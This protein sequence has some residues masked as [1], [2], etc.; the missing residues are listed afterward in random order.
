MNG[1]RAKRL[2]RE[3]E[4]LTA[5]R[6]DVQYRERTMK[7]VSVPIPGRTDGHMITVDRATRMLVPGCTRSL[8]QDMKRVYR[9][10]RSGRHEY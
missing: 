6:P 1:Q 8:C 10:V 7:Q 4:R 5:G 3:A 2:R 9:N